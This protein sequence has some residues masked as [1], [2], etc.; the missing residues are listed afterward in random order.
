MTF[1]EGERVKVLIAEGKYH[2]GTINYVRFAAPEYYK[3]EVYSV[4]LD[5]NIE[6]QKYSGSIFTADRVFENDG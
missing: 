2:L 5:D 1:R 3:P 4:F 6:K